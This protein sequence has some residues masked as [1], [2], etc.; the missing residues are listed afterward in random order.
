MTNKAIGL[1]L[2]LGLVLTVTACEGNEEE[3]EED[4]DDSRIENPQQIV[5]GE[6]NPWRFHL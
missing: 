2:A 3:G 1:L 5:S 6:R 4:D